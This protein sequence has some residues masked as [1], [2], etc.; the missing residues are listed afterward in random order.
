[1]RLLLMATQYMLLLRNLRRLPAAN[2][3]S[4]KSLQMLRCHRHRVA[5]DASAGCQQAQKSLGLEALLRWQI[6]MKHL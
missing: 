6:R 2:Q 5:T 1:M 4:L 3:Q